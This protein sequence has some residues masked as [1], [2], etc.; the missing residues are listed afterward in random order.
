M[1]FVTAQT[2]QSDSPLYEFESLIHK[3]KPARIVLIPN[4]MMKLSAPTNTQKNAFT[5]PTATAIASAI[6]IADPIAIPY[7]MFKTPTMLLASVI[8]AAHERS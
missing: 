8:T 4:V 2:S 1:R 6:A 5:N 7:L 3:V